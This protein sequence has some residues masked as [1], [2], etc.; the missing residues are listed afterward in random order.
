ML[1]ARMAAFALLASLSAC[2]NSVVT[3][4]KEKWASG[5]GNF[6]GENPRG[7]MVS[8]ARKAG[9]KVGGTRS[10][11][12]ALLGNPDSTGPR[13]DIWYLGRGG[14]A[15]DYETFEIK[16]DSNDIATDVRVIQT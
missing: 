1:I 2:G 8:D 16:Y 11:I 6:E 12:R 7:S 4:D 10:S 9:V 13:G 15:P 14:Y 5:K 3:F